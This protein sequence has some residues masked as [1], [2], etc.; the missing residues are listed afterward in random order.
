MDPFL[1]LIHLSG[2]PERGMDN[3][4]PLPHHLSVYI[5]S[6]LTVWPQSA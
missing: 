1:L 4:P 6:I 2:V 5:K 3:N